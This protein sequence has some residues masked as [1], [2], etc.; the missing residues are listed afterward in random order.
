MIG[1]RVRW[2]KGAAQRCLKIEATRQMS[3]VRNHWLFQ[4]VMQARLSYLAMSKRHRIVRV[5]VS[6]NRW[7]TLVATLLL[8]AVN[9]PYVQSM[10]IHN[11]LILI[12]NSSLACSQGGYSSDTTHATVVIIIFRDC[13]SKC[14]G[15]HSIA[16]T[17]S[18]LVTHSRSNILL[19]TQQLIHKY[20]ILGS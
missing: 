4:F 20:I 7:A 13:L 2:L 1:S 6:E 9:K 8:V 15:K 14:Q 18:D 17:W 3:M 10:N 19:S 12:S 16:R 11:T 5:M